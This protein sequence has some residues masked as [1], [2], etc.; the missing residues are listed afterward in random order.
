MEKFSL[1]FWRKN[2]MH[3]SFYL[4]EALAYHCLWQFPHPAYGKDRTA[5]IDALSDSEQCFN[6]I[7]DFVRL[8]FQD[9]QQSHPVQIR[10]HVYH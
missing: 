2:L 10:V 8:K 6:Q 7:A 4:Q 1:Y 5:G 3:P 9:P